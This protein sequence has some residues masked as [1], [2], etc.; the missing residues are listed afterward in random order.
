M[1][2]QHAKRTVFPTSVVNPSKGSSN[3]YSI[4][5]R[6]PHSL[7]AFDPSERPDFHEDGG[8]TADDIS[9]SSTIASTAHS[10]VI[11][12]HPLDLFTAFRKSSNHKLCI[13]ALQF[14]VSGVIK[15]YTWARV[16][17]VWLP[18]DGQQKCI[19]GLRLR[20]PPG[21]SRDNSPSSA[22]RRQ[23]L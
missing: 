19:T 10:T 3:G 22:I 4:F 15:G 14:Y 11:S 6:G 23:L 7:D 2:V 9:G 17:L 21:E 5:D 20:Q 18:L 16:R 8:T 13:T 12:E 1:L